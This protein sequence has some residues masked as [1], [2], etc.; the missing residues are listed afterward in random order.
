MLR[1][2]AAM[3]SK[4]DSPGWW[5]CKKPGRRWEPVLLFELHPGCLCD[6]SEYPQPI[7]W[8][9]RFQKWIF[10]EKIAPRK[11]GGDE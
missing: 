3:S 9:I 4:P 6:D 5:W 2:G 8:R 7:S 10:A 1:T 11:G